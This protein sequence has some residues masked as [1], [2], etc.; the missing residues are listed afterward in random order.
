M[1]EARRD[2]AVTVGITDHAQD[3]LGDN[4]FAELPEVGSELAAGGRSWCCR[5]GQSSVRYFMPRFPGVVVEINENLQ[6]TPELVNSDPYH[7]GWF[8]PYQTFR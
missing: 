7:D 2:G 8:F 1:G 4:G 5:V 3:L 6:D